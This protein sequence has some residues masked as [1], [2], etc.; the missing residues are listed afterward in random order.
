MVFICNAKYHER[1]KMVCAKFENKNMYMYITC[2]R[3][4]MYI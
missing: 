4:I 3:L 2:K 1:A